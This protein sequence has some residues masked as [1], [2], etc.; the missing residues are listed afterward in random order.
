MTEIITIIVI[1]VILVYI[2]FRYGKAKERQKQN[3]L[4]I[5]TLQ[6][7]EKISNKP[8]V[9]NPFSRMRDKK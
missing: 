4:N 2:S 7:Y 6:K 8:N 1:V 3:K 9:S 5:E